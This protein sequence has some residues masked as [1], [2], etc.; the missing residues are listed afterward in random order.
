IAW[1][2]AQQQRAVVIP[3]VGARTQEQLADNLGALDVELTAA[4]LER[5]DA[6]SRIELGFP[7]DFGAGRLAYGKTF[8][9]ID[10]HR[11]LVDPLV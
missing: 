4:E 6:V 2:R 3:I 8:E 9:L 7:H 10:D 11:R 1:V 5:L